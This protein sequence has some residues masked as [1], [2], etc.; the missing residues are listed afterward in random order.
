MNNIPA[1]VEYKT[2]DEPKINVPVDT[3]IKALVEAH[4]NISINSLIKALSDANINIINDKS[5]DISKNIPVVKSNDANDIEPKNN[6]IDTA[7][8]TSPQSVEA[9]D[10]TQ[11]VVP[12]LEEVP[13]ES[14]IK[15]QEVNDVIFEAINNLKKQQQ[16]P[17]LPQM[18]VEDEASYQKPTIEIPEPPQQPSQP[19]QAPEPDQPS[20]PL[21]PST[22]ISTTTT[23][24]RER[25]YYQP[26]LIPQPFPVHY[27]IQPIIQMIPQPVQYL[28]QQ[29]RPPY[30]R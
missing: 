7:T 1:P 26:I 30:Y 11:L 16:A 4:V 28:M 27:I 24:I 23:R 19:E 9:T 22:P 3:L 2:V 20:Q 10:D 21:P 18:P 12:P 29:F 25:I 8:S 6:Y 14:Q 17:E 13:I 5:V 15:E